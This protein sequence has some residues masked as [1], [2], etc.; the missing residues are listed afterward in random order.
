MKEERLYYEAYEDRYRQVH[1]EQ[2]QW[3]SDVPS[4]IVMEVLLRY[5]IRPGEPVLEIGCGEGRDA[6]YLLKE[7]IPV[8]ATDISAEAVRYCRDKYPEFRDCFQILDC[9]GGAMDCKFRFIYAVAVLHMLV[10]EEDRAGF[11]RF[12]RNHLA[13]QGI[14][15]ICTMGDGKTERNSDISEAF[16]LQQRCHQQTG[17]MLTIAGT[18]CRMVGFDTWLRELDENGLAVLEHGVT[19]VEPEFPQMMYA[20]VTRK[21]KRKRMKDT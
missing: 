18:S 8:L 21:N 15:L 16:E 19:S 5:G 20:V 13:E 1:A 3:A 10:R 7:G 17:R 14:G 12:F 2:L 4:G 6:A 11:F 9:I